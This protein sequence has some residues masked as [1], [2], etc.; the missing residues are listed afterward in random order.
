MAKTRPAQRLSAASRNRPQTI[1]S[2]STMTIIH[3]S[4]MPR[5]D[6]PSPD[7]EWRGRPGADLP[8]L[9][10]GL[11]AASPSTARHNVNEASRPRLSSRPSRRAPCDDHSRSSNIHPLTERCVHRSSMDACVARGCL[12]RQTRPVPGDPIAPRGHLLPACPPGRHQHQ[13]RQRQRYRQQRGHHREPGTSGDGDG[14][15]DPSGD[16]DGDGDPTVTGGDGD[17]DGDGEDFTQITLTLVPRP[18]PISVDAS[19]GQVTT[20][21]PGRRRLLHSGAELRD[22]LDTVF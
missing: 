16:G 10:S 1:P 14:D 8:V 6:P 9:D 5:Q 15:G 3:T 17:G 18:Q 13:H 21:A 11:T 20:P 19:E 7:S 2:P 4:S 12:R 22:C